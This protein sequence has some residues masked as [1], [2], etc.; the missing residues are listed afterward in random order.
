[1][2]D[3]A[4]SLPQHLAV[5]TLA[6]LSHLSAAYRSK[7]VFATAT[8]PA[9]ETL[10]AAVT[11]HAV[12]GWKPVEAVLNH[13]DMFKTLNRADVHWPQA[14]Q[15]RTWIDLANE[16]RR[17]DQVLVVCN[18]KRYALAL[19]D[20]LKDADGVFQVLSHE[21]NFTKLTHYL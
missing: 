6:A 21:A 11:K 13:V 2:F 12:S 3:E 8:Q 7:V 19:L 1:M 10:N 4:Q 18:L 17:T 16:V 15:R 5:P 20:E 9:F 14:G